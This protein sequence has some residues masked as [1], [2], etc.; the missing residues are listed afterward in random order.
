MNRIY[1]F[2]GVAVTILSLWHYYLWKRLAFDTNLPG[3][4][5]YIAATILAM[6]ALSIPAMQITLR[7]LGE[8]PKPFAYGA[9]LWMGAAVFLFLF[10][11]MGD[12]GYLL[13]WLWGKLTSQPELDPERRTTI[14]RLIGGAA[15]F[16]SAGV[17]SLGLYNALYDRRVTRTQ[18]P[19]KNLPEAL[20]GTRIVQL[21]DLHIGPTLRK[22]FVE[23]VVQETNDLSPDLIV[24]TGDLVDGSVA[25]LQAQ[26]APLA[27]L[28]AKHG[29]FFITGNHELYSGV[30]EW[31]AEVTRLGIRVLR[32]ECVVIGEGE[33]T[34]TLAGVDDYTLRGGEKEH[35]EDLQKT[36]AGRD[37]NKPVVLLAHQ[38]KSAS[39]AAAHNVDLQLSGHTH[40]GQLFPWGLLVKLQQGFLAGLHR[41]QNTWVYVSRGTGFWGPPV[42]VGS[43]AE[44]AELTLIPD[45]A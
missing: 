42:R 41:H 13:W 44:I 24:I 35:T 30:E 34:F 8:V 38:P 3:N 36:L 31:C 26:V 7:T 45:E 22:E 5:K 18:I 9:Y 37:P 20:R 39:L 27:E 16:G 11:L 4:W 43:Y 33:D 14:A 17:S 1:W 23:K 10:L 29:V 40:G 19:L 2:L 12:L 28:R 25:Q 15:L 21:T 32:N 6:L